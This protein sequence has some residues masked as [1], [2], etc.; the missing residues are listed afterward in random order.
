MT[1]IETSKKGFGRVFWILNTIEMW[2][3]LAFYNLR[4]MA[5]IYIMQ[6]DNPGG[7]H[8]TA[9]DKGTIYAWWAAFQSLLPIV[10]G[11]YADRFGYKR[12]LGFALSLM[13]LGYLMIAFLRDLPFISNYWGL[14]SGIMVLATGTAFFK[15]SLQGSLAHI[16]PREKSSVGWGIFYWVVNVGAFIG[17]YLPTAILA[18]SLFLPGPFHAIANSKEAWRTLFLAS[19]VFTSF[20]LILLFTF[21]DVPSG[22]SKTESAW[23]VLLRTVKHVFEPRLLAWLLIMSAFWLMMY[24]LWDLQPNFIADWVDSSSM[25]NGLR[26]L[27]GIIYQ[28]L[29]E[30]TPRGPM[31]PQQVLL[32]FNAFFIILF[33]VGISWLM[34]KMR[35][36]TAMSFGMIFAIAGI[37]TAGLTN[38]AWIIVLGI[39]FFSLGEMMTGPKKT[40]YLSL[41][42]PAD[43]KALYLG[44]VNIPVGI[45]VY[46]GSTLAGYVYGHFGEKAVLAL[47]YLAEHSAFGEGKVWNGDISTLESALGV[48][49]TS[50]MLK[51]Q[52]VTGL[53]ASAATELLWKTYSPQYYV[54]I[55]FA[56]IGVL[57]AVAL[58]IF[59]RM[60]RRWNDMNA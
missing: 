21:K 10:T 59:G 17:H 15:P 45:G 42:A 39:F 43:K 9:T 24:Q 1:S 20:N 2:E 32:S 29:V 34:R 44:Y 41:I 27:P 16:L 11:G 47:R 48:A 18:L 57:A 52:E 14:F 35:T 7:L 30:Q 33:V 38:S 3:R 51:L 23:N 28:T 5:P 60:A 19:A 53:D 55:P 6:A 46:L 50:S 40:E 25:A 49:R 37:L 54:W 36:L 12:T 31:I 26:W 13:M 58:I 4:V 8:L 22:S 56:C